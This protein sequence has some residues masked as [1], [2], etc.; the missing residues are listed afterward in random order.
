MYLRGGWGTF[1]RSLEEAIG[2]SVDVL[3]AAGAVLDASTSDV[4]NARS[5]LASLLPRG[6]IDPQ[7]AEVNLDA[8]YQVTLKFGERRQLP[9]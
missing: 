1:E 7:G 6:T 5:Q 8:R 9:R 4:P 2:A 3:N